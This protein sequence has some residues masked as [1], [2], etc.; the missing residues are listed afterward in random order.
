MHYYVMLSRLSAM[1][2]IWKYGGRG[3]S[4]SNRG[5]GPSTPGAGPS[6]PGAGPTTPGPSSSASAS[7]ADVADE[8]E[9][10]NGR[11]ITNPEQLST[12][13]KKIILFNNK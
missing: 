11:G 7:F 10:E 5:R 4:S 13:K 2:R 8:L 9:S 12:Q 3:G 1:S 6:T